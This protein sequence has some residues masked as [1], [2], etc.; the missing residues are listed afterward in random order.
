MTIVNN[1]ISLATYLADGKRK[2]KKIKTQEEKDKEAADK[3]EAAK[4]GKQVEEKPEEVEWIWAPVRIPE[5]SLVTGLSPCEYIFAEFKA[6]TPTKKI[7]FL[8]KKW[9]N[10]TILRGADRLKLISRY[11]QFSSSIL[12]H[13]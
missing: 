13:Y 2:P 7:K 3:A 6:D 10:N 12:A 4:L 8:Y 9:P 5:H 1:T 11:S